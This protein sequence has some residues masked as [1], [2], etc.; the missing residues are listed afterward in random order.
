MLLHDL[1]QYFR[2]VVLLSALIHY[3]SYGYSESLKRDSMDK[4]KHCIQSLKGKQVVVSSVPGKY[5]IS[6]S[7]MHAN[8]KAAAPVYF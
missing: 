7:N 3:Y 6:I 8:S 1:Q 4:G 2:L 5:Y